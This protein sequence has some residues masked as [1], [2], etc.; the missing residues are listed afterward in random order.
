MHITGNE[1]TAA[2]SVVAALAIIGGYL[3]VRSANQNALKISRE[4]RSSKQKEE[5][6]SIKRTIYAKLMDDLMAV[7]A[8][9]M[10]LSSLG[11]DPR[12]AT[13]P[14][15]KAARKVNSS[16]S[17]MLLVSNNEL[18][19]PVARKAQAAAGDCTDRSSDQHAFF[20]E[21][22]NLQVLLRADLAGKRISSVEE[23]ARMADGSDL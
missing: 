17:Q 16:I 1:L 4:E 20:R 19:E 6:D 3:G 18:A 13:G 9:S 15:L 2:S 12:S 5:L 8:V 7:A 11:K 14:G 21:L 23:L 22:S 10:E